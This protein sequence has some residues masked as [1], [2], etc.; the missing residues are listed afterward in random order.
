MDNNMFHG[1]IPASLG[2]ASRLELIGLESNNFAGQIPSSLGKLPN[3]YDLYLWGN[4][5]EASDQESWAFLYALANC[6]SSCNESTVI[7]V[8]YLGANRLSGKVPPIIQNLRGLFA[9]GLDGN[10]LTGTIEW[11]GKLRNL[12]HLYLQENRFVG[13]IPSSIGNL[14]NLSSLV[15]SKNELSGHIPSNLGNLRQL[16]M[17]NLS[18]NN[19]EGGIPSNLGNLGQLD[20]LDLSSNMLRGIIP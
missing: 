17:L 7:Q 6:T 18:Q 20:H 2:N 11:I 13:T 8:L 19:L 15:L 12:V 16:Q 5:I 10:N 3:L 9:L 4:S 14:T 1:H